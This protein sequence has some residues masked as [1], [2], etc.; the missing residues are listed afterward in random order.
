MFSSLLGET[1]LRCFALKYRKRIPS[2]KTNHAFSIFETTQYM[3]SLKPNI[4]IQLPQ[5]KVKPEKNVLQKIKAVPSRAPVVSGKMFESTR[6][7]NLWICRSFKFN[8]D[9]SPTARCRKLHCF[10]LGTLSQNLETHTHTKRLKFPSK[11]LL[12]IKIHP[13]F[14]LQ[15]KYQQIQFLQK[16]E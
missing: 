15:T 14:F 3:R 16:F 13:P 1:S 2:M 8:R 12:A 6:L 7:G 9:R 5:S 4:E 10:W 11:N